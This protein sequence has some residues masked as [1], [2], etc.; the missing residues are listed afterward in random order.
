MRVNNSG[1]A[2]GVHK[3]TSASKAKPKKASSA[4]KGGDS[5]HV[6]DSATLR[7]KALVMLADMPEVRME[8]IEAIRDALENGTFKQDSRKVATQ[9]IANALAE[10]PWS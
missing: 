10:H 5:V 6:T 2:T 3:A 4:S 1:A 9:I 8:R 7:E